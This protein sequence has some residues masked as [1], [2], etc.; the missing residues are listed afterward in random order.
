MA[1]NL[2]PVT[3]DFLARH[4]VMTLATQGEAGPWAAALFY[5][6]DGDGLVFLSSPGSRHCRDLALRPRCAATIQSQPDDWRGIQG[7]QLEGQV[8]EL[9]GAERARAERLYGERFS[10]VRPAGAPAAILAALARVRW[11]RLD[12]ARLYFI[13]NQRGFGSRE[14]FDA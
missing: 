9:Q 2:P 6:R 8:S 3:A 14:Q 4:H 13:D 7:I 5:V 1:L 12:I 11:Y 10:F